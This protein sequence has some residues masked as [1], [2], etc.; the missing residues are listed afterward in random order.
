MVHG[1]EISLIFAG[2]LDTIDDILPILLSVHFC[3]WPLITVGVIEAFQSFWQSKWGG[4]FLHRMVGI[5]AAV[6]GFQLVSSPEAGTLVMIGDAP[7][8]YGVGHF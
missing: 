3:G 5:L 4:L 6:A 7:L 2:I 8:F 1:F